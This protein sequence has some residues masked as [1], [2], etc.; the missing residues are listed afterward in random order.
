[1]REQ[2]AV[3][4]VVIED[5]DPFAGELI[6]PGF[7]R[8]LAGFGRQVQYDGKGAAEVRLRSGGEGAPHE[9]GEQVRNSES[10]AGAAVAT[11]GGIVDLREG[12]K[13]LADFI[14]G[15]TDSGVGDLKFED[16]RSP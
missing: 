15:N 14:S 16:R 7:V 8:R 13:E 9:F 5:Q 11:G 6:H 10:Q 1:M 12:L 2:F 3:G 4:G